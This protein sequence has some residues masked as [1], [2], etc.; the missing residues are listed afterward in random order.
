[1]VTCKRICSTA[2]GTTP[3]AHLTSTLQTKLHKARAFFKASHRSRG[4]ASRVLPSSAFCRKRPAQGT[5]WTTI[6]LHAGRS[7]V[8]GECSAFHTVS[9][10]CLSKVAA[11]SGCDH[12][13][14]ALCTKSPCIAT[15]DLPLPKDNERLPIISPFLHP[16]L[17]FVKPQFVLIVPI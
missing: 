12:P 3:R 14:I 13:S 9:V 2:V 7:N 16:D 6:F 11:T 17:Q 4:K 5:H 1:M 10:C 8:F 15:G